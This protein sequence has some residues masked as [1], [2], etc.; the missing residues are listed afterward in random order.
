[1]HVKR[2]ML[3]RLEIG[4]MTQLMTQ[5]F[6]NP[7]KSRGLRLVVR[8]S[9]P[10][11]RTKSEREIVRIF[12]CRFCA[13][14]PP[15]NR[16]FC[17]IT[18]CQTA[19]GDEF[20]VGFADH[21]RV[22]LGGAFVDD[23]FVQGVIDR[24]LLQGDGADVK[25]K[26]LENPGVAAAQ[27]AKA[28][29]QNFLLTSTI[30]DFYLCSEFPDVVK[31]SGIAFPHGLRTIDAAARLGQYDGHG[32]DDAVVV[33][34]AEHNAP[35]FE[36]L[37]GHGDG[38]VAKD[39]PAAEL[40]QLFMHGLPAVAFLG[41]QPVGAGKDG[42]VFQ[43]G[44]G[45][46]HGAQI[47]AI[48]QIQRGRARLDLP[49]IIRVD[50]V[51]LQA[52][53]VEIGNF[54]VRAE[55]I[56]CVE[57]RRVGIIA[58]NAAGEGLRAAFAHGDGVFVRKGDVRA[59]GLQGRKGEIDIG[60][61]FKGRDDLDARGTVEIGQCEDQ[62][63]DKLAADIAAHPILPAR[64]PAAERE[65]IFLLAEGKMLLAAQR[66]I[67]VQRP[68]E[69]P[70]AAAQRDLPAKAQRQRDE[71]AQRAAAFPALKNG[72]SRLHKAAGIDGDG[73]A[74]D[75]NL[76]AEGFEAIDAGEDVLAVINAGQPADALRKRGADQIPVRH[77]FGGRRADA[78]LERARFEGCNHIFCPFRIQ[79]V[80]GSAP[81]AC[82]GY[83]PLPRGRLAYR[84]Q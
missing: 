43:R 67:H 47:G 30:M 78:A 21:A 71:K 24:A 1:M 72:R 12:L 61:A 8:G 15:E 65:G 14:K 52:V 83:S 74:A 76:S 38:V 66:F 68:L 39:Q 27:K 79:G 3:G 45:K 36:G 77:A 33:V 69:Q 56:E 7:Y 58:F 18:F 70:R 32:H 48:R 2:R 4:L 73:V 60:P 75:L 80:T 51:A 10:V 23:F 42:A 26:A 5:D 16:W 9:S 17:C 50:P 54:N 62:P 13:K 59:E 41:L 55:E 6:A 22:N 28:D 35:V 64:Q 81:H 34:P 53:L 49:E 29:D 63:G 82:G 19:R 37:F 20:H 46:Q 11:S 31:K 44:Q 40:H 25:T 57:K 84:A